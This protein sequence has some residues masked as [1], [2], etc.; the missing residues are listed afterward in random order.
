MP[1]EHRSFLDT[2]WARVVA[3]LVA[4]VFAGLLVWLNRDALTGGTNAA[5]GPL[6]ACLAE[7]LAHVDRLIADGVV[8]AGQ[9]DEFRI[10]ARQFCEQTV[11]AG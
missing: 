10:R 1:S 8:K 3:G 2:I 9:A 6:A 7:R 4:L 5:A 11:P